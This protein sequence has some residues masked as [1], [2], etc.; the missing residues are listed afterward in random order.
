M[1]FLE[2]KILYFSRNLLKILPTPLVSLLIFK[3]SGNTAQ[4]LGFPL[5]KSKYILWV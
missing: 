3:V 1:N 4:E 5:L 2:Y